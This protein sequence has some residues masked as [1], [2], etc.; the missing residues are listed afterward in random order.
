MKFLTKTLFYTLFLFFSSNNNLKAQ[1]RLTIENNS[2]RTMTVKIMQGLRKNGKLH[3]I[4]KIQPFGRETTYFP[5]SGYYYTK[6][7][8]ILDGKNPVYRKGQPFE[9]KNDVSGYSILTLTFTIKETSIPQASGGIS[10]S[11]SEYD[12]N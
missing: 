6:T 3:E 7:K 8:A 4:I 5:N 1:A 10:I 12:E 9:V 11:K 2:M